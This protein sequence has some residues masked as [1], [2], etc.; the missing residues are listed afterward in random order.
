[1]FFAFG[2]RGKQLVISA[3]SRWKVGQRAGG[4]LSWDKD[5]SFLRMTSGA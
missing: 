4:S 3:F 2:E 1:M 5:E